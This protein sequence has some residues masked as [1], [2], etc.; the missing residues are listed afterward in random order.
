M[1]Q[2]PTPFW[3]LSFWRA[4]IRLMS[5]LVDVI[6]DTYVCCVGKAVGPDQSPHLNACRGLVSGAFGSQKYDLRA[7]FLLFLLTMI[8][9]FILD[10]AMRIYKLPQ[11]RRS[12]NTARLRWFVLHAVGN[13]LVCCVS[14]QCVF[15]AINNPLELV[16][17]PEL[18]RFDA[19]STIACTLHL[20]HVIYFTCSQ[21][22]W[23]HHISF[24]AAGF[25]GQWICGSYSGHLAGLYHFFVTG[26]PGW[27]RHL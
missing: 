18:I 1:E 25:I 17:H 9:L 11:C 26:L 21:K 19:S 15:R 14:V 22:D 6:Y 23:I 8:F 5:L 20:Y 10:I 24:V 13:L 7:N 3:G 27:V 4:L 12:Q 2:N 16:S